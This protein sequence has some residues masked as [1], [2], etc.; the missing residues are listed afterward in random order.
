MRLVLPVMYCKD[1]SISKMENDIP[2]ESSDFIVI[3]AIFYTIDT[4]EMFKNA[5][6]QC[7]VS[8]S[9][10]NYRVALSMKEVDK[11]IM[12]QK[13]LMFYGEN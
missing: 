6:D 3:H 11:K 10:G 13:R 7:I 5:P 8:N 4:I 2:L 12:H 9:S 1:T